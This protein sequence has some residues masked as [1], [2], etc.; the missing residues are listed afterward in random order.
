MLY[1]P[2]NNSFTGG[3]IM[4]LLIIGGVAGGASAAARARR[5]DENAEIVMIERGEYISFANCGLPYHIGGVIQDRERLLV[6][7]PEEM[8]AKFNFDIRIKTEAISIDRKNKNVLLKD[9]KTDKEY[10]ESYDKLILSPGAS[11]FKPPIPGVNSKKIL[12]LRNINDMDAIINEVEKV[13]T[14]NNP[15]TIAVIGGGYVGIET[16]ENIRELGLDVTLIEL[17]GQIMGPADPEMAVMLENEMIEKGIDLKLGVSVSSFKDIDEQSIELTISNGKK[18]NASFVVMAIGVKPEIQ[19]ASDADL[20]I[21][22]RGGISV[23]NSMLSSD[24]N[25]YAVGDAIEVIDFN[26][27]QNSLIPLAGPANRQGRIAAENALGGNKVYTSTQGTAVCKIFDLTF[28][29]T[30]LSEKAAKRNNINYD[31]LYILP[32]S[33][34]TYYPGA[35]SMTF[36]LLFDPDTG[37]VLGA[38][39]VGAEKIEKRIDVIAVAVRAGLTVEDI[40]EL[41]LSYAPPYGSA[42]DPVNYAGFVAN[43]IREGLFSQIWPDEKLNPKKGMTIVDVRVAEELSAGTI[44][45][46]IHIPLQEIRSRLDELDKQDEIIVFCSVGLRGYLAARIL[47]QLGF[48]VK[49]LSGGF[50]I[51]QLFHNPREALY[52]RSE[53]TDDAGVSADT[54][55]EIPK[56]AEALEK[57]AVKKIDACGLQCPGPIMRL[58]KGID[59]INVDQIL[60]ITV[61]DSG[62]KNDAPAWCKSTGNQLVNLVRDGKNF[63]AFIQKGSKK[64]SVVSQLTNCTKKMT[65]VIFSNDLDKAIASLIIANGAAAAGYQVT[66]FYTFWGLST[67]RKEESPPVSKGFMDKMFGWMLPK[68]MNKL[69]LSKM[70]ML[71][72]GT[73]M[74]KDVMK[75]KNVATLPE[76]LA[77]AIEQ[78]VKIVACKMSMD[79]MGIKEEELIDGVEISGVAHYIDEVSSSNAGMFI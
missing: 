9:L 20:K 76:L 62:F 7:T 58:K 31:K 73:I 49:N 26:T 55:H 75:K 54:H 2:V 37:K 45:G 33:H 34:A 43:N 12:T 30:G 47:T 13:K 69:K 60:K 10:T 41:E 51:Y 21:G 38:Q 23:N 39:A 44:S 8:N 71:G 29:M 70:N 40:S 67:L 3:F 32:A 18:I 36:K 52:D 66:L 64:C 56:D 27:N 59:E 4:K 72:M 14:Q 74:M 35:M 42:K 77:Q 1:P 6:T 25:I 61:S 15:G 24:E 68:G 48:K 11:P 57:I 79:V 63:S 65:N 78:G 46:A 22:K 28:A 19:L 53:L 16:A 5:L 17:A 50:K